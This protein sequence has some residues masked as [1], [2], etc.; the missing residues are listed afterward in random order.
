ME[1]N[2]GTIEKVTLFCNYR[3]RANK[4]RA[5]YSK[6]IFWALRLPLFARLRYI[7]KIG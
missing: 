4:G 6:I 2:T 7:L 5:D 1:L 3:T